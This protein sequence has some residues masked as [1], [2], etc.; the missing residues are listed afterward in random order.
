VTI[1]SLAVIAIIIAMLPLSIP[2]AMAAKHAWPTC[3]NFLSQDDAQAIYDAD[4]SDRFK[5]VSKSS[6]GAPC[7]GN[8]TFGTQPLV[9]CDALASAPDAQTA[10]Q[11][12]LDRTSV[13]GDPYGLDSDGDGTACDQA[14]GK[15][16]DAETLDAPQSATPQDAATPTDAT[17]QPD[18]G[19]AKKAKNGGNTTGTDT[20]PPPSAPSGTNNSNTPPT[21]TGGNDVI[22]TTSTGGGESGESLDARLEARF[23]ELEAQFAAFSGHDDTTST[24]RQSSPVVVSTAPPATTSAV[25]SSIPTSAS[26][27]GTA[28]TTALHRGHHGHGKGHGKHHKSHKNG[29]HHHKKGHH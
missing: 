22:V 16:G 1:R 25:S 9:S 29:K 3:E 27:T 10:L 5:L 6:N 20:T 4:T 2:T 18:T 11:G 8:V 15:G 23:A 14:S 13:S 17:S 19:K 28:T 26:S 7:Q 21:V 12:L 24:G